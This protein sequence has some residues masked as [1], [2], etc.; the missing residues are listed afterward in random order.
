MLNWA[1]FVIAAGVLLGWAAVIA[2]W[3]RGRA[4][5]PDLH[6]IMLWNHQGLTYRREDGV[7]I[8]EE[9]H[10]TAGFIHYYEGGKVAVFRYQNSE[11]GTTVRRAAIEQWHRNDGSM[12]IVTEPERKHI[13]HTLLELFTQRGKDFEIA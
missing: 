13:V 7:R 2:L 8:T 9:P 3:R 12:V 10:G 6:P 11:H 4:T 5:N 1:P